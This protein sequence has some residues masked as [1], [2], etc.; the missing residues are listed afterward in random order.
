LQDVV[1]SVKNGGSGKAIVTLRKNQKHGP[2][3]AITLTIPEQTFQKTLLSIL[4]NSN[5]TLG[6]I[7]EITVS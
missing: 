7:G 6:E 3:Y 5:A 2:T 4:R 1:V